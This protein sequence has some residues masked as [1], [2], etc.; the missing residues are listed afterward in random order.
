MTTS[1]LQRSEIFA[2]ATTTTASSIRLLIHL[3]VSP[4]MPGG[5]SSREV[6]QRH[7]IIEPPENSFS[8]SLSLSILILLVTAGEGEYCARS[9]VTSSTFIY[10]DKRV[11]VMTCCTF[12]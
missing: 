9:V 5:E 12:L 7:H 6:Q 4:R 8:L 3:L 1:L 2:E 11:V 10:P